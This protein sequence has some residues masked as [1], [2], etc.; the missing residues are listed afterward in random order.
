MPDMYFEKRQ[1]N[2]HTYEMSQ[3]FSLFDCS[4]CFILNWSYYT[5]N[6]W[7]LTL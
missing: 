5:I 7:V 2:V 6:L 4:T 1:V 3:I